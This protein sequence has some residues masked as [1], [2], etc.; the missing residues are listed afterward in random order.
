[1]PAEYQAGMLL[2]E[3][4]R[5][6][7]ALAAFDKALALNPRATDAIVGKGRLALQQIE[8]GD[9]EQLAT[10]ALSINARHVGAMMLY[11]DVALACGD[12]AAAA[13]ALN[14]VC[15]ID[16]RDEGALGR[17]AAIAKMRPKP[18]RDFEAL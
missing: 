17:L 9:A 5:K 1:W 6:A 2:L 10:R 12:D 8:L 14:K 4:F 18:G 11:A 13:L 16:P 15:G 3:K 7:E